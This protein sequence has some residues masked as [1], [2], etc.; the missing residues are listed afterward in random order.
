MRRVAGVGVTTTL[1]F[2]GTVKGSTNDSNHDCVR[3]ES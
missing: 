2:S 1:E 3:T